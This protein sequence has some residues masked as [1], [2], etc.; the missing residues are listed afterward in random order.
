MMSKTVTGESIEERVARI[1]DHYEKTGKYFD[2]KTSYSADYAWINGNKHIS[3]EV[4]KLWEDIHKEEVHRIVK[5]EKSE[6]PMEKPTTSIEAKKVSDLTLCEVSKLLKL[7][8]EKTVAELIAKPSKPKEPEKVDISKLET[9]L[10]EDIIRKI[11][12]PDNTK[13]VVANPTWKRAKELLEYV[14]ASEVLKTHLASKMLF[15]NP[16]FTQEIIKL[17]MENPKKTFYHKEKIV[18]RIFSYLPSNKV[19]FENPANIR[20][21]VINCF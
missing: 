13:V 1:R 9:I 3:E 4:A 18:E 7:I 16:V 6:K 15:D 21:L 20:D 11:I 12:N 8:G 2:S 19:F 17:V 14:Y 10:P 5:P